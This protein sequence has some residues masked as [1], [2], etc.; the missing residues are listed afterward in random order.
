MLTRYFMQVAG[1]ADS[2]VFPYDFLN[3]F[4]LSAPSTKTTLAYHVD[5]NAVVLRQE[6]VTFG[7]SQNTF[8]EPLPDDDSDRKRVSG[9]GELLCC[10]QI[11][12][13]F[14]LGSIELYV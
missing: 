14:N 9:G 2:S 1:I 13:L 8:S 3:T 12:M 5:Q 11:V 4:G 7:F 6:Q 10:L